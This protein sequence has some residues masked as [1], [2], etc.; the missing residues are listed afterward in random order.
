MLLVLGRPGSGCTSLLRVLSN[1]RD[2]FDEVTGETRF[3]SMDHREA[4]QYR[5]QIM[6]NNEDDLHF[7]TLTVNR[8][9]KF[10]L[11][12]KIPEER[13][14]HLANRKD[15][16]LNKRDDILDSLGIGHTKKNMVGN[17]FIRGVSGGERKRVSLAEVLA[18]QS[19]VQM[20]DNPTRGLDSKSAL[21]FA[22]MLRA[23]ADRNDKTIVTT[24]YQAGNGIYDQF[25]KVLVL[26][27]GRVTYSGPRRAAR[28][29]FENL[30]FICPKGAN[31]ADFLTSVTVLTERI[32]R[33]GWEE[34]VPNTPED[35]EACFQKSP[36]HKDQMD[37][38]V[39]PE[40]L[41]Y[42]TEDL[43]LAVSSEKKKQHI[44][45]KKSV[46]TAKLWDQVGACIVRQFQIMW[47]DKF[48]LYV[49]VCCLGHHTSI[50][51]RVFVL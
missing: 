26:A 3:A 42:E 27:E 25:D 20:W 32:V 35:F 23:E 1:D 22:R 33:P 46:Y 38:I 17:E 12:N 30:G 45:R 11:R 50:G 49:K 14:D 24:T 36:I 48:S 4:K 31:I 41:S 6:F 37:A 47:G 2:S 51:L 29:Y 16:V 43:A 40:K 19:P 44:P 7:P 18:G 5:Q 13:P 15:F 21:A 39:E 9:M 34:K 10:A 8:T 28:E